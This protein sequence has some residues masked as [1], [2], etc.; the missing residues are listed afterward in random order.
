[1]VARSS[2]FQGCSRVP[3]ILIVAIGRDIEEALA[4]SADRDVERAE[5]AA[6]SR[7]RPPPAR[8]YANA[9]WVSRLFA[10]GL[11]ARRRWRAGVTLHE[12]R[13]R[14]ARFVDATGTAQRENS[15]RIRFGP[16][17]AGGEAAIV[18]L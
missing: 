2:V 18:A 13:S 4:I 16:Q 11:H 15:R 12:A 1:M 14:S 8:P 3:G 9:R 17:H 7:A 5:L 10:G 6:E